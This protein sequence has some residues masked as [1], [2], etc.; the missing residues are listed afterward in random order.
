MSY[1]EQLRRRIVNRFYP[2]TGKSEA[3]ALEMAHWAIERGL[4]EPQPSD[5]AKQGAD[6]LAKAMREEYFTDPQGRT[7]RAKHAAR[8]KRKEDQKQKTLWADMRWASR[9]H[10]QTAFQQRRHQILGDCRQLNTDV[11]SFNENK[12]VDRPI[13]IGFDF[14]R[15]LEEMALV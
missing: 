10:M 6:Q 8:V 7:V 15:D 12:N 11:D 1:N 5:S 3:T 4:W 13:Q 2:E 14:T 9:E